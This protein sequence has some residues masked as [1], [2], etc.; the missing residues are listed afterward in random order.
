V[1]ALLVLAAGTIGVAVLAPAD[2]RVWIAAGVA[3]AG[4][5]A[6]AP[7]VLRWDPQYGF[8]AIIFLFAIVWGTDTAAYF[9]GRII[10]GPKLVPRLSPH[11]TWAGALVGLLAAMIAGLIVAQAAKLPGPLAIAVLTAFLSICAQGGDLWESV[12]KRRFGAKDSGRLIPGHGG[13][14]DRLDGFVAAGVVAM[15]IGIARGGLEAP[16][17]GLLAW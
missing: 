17:R 10:G 5:I 9:G 16:G 15:L 8:A 4:A 1:A 11:K 3:Y 13:L 12:L 6:A 2:R 7:V 14:M